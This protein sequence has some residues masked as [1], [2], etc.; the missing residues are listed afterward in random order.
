MYEAGFGRK[1]VVIEIFEQLKM[2]GENWQM[3]NQSLCF[4]DDHEK[5]CAVVSVF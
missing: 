5:Y 3:R 2:F 4:G 1:Y